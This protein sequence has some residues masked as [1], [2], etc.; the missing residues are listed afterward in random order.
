[1]ACMAGSREPLIRAHLPA[2][3]AKMPLSLV[4]LCHG[5]FLFRLGPFG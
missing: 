1:M 3:P 2:A 4:L 5:F